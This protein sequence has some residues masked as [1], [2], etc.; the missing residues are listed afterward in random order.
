M[1]PADEVVV[2]SSHNAAVAHLVRSALTHEGI[3][4]TLR[5]QHLAPLMGEVPADD[6]RAEVAVAAVDVERALAVVRAAAR[7]DWPDQDCPRCG[8]GNPGSFEICWSCGA[9]LPTRGLKLV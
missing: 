5:R 6:A 7:E 2:F 1:I 3:A 4:S 9:D 8:E